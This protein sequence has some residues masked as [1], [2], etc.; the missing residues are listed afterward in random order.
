M[1]ESVYHQL[2]PQ[3][4]P[5]YRCVED[6]FEMFEMVYEDW[7]ERQ[8]G[9]FRPYVNRVIYRYLDS[10]ILKNGF[11]RVRCGDRGH[12]YL[13]AFSCKH[14][15]FCPSCHLKRVVEFGTWLGRKVIKAV[16][17]QHAVLSIPKNLRRY[18]FTTASCFR[19]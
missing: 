6:H 12:K 16:P 17:H 13:L 11:A 3:S 7:Y 19:N 14:R 8:Y 2:N 10:G 9:F 18:I 15:H 4:S 1:P 5:Y